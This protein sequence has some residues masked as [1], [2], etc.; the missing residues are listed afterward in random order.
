MMAAISKD[1]FDVDRLFTELKGI[2]W[3]VDRF[4][5]F[6]SNGPLPPATT[7][8]IQTLID[9]VVGKL[10]VMPDY[11]DV[12]LKMEVHFRLKNLLE[13]YRTLLES[14]NTFTT[15]V[16]PVTNFEVDPQ[17]VPSSSSPVEESS[18]TISLSMTSLSSSLTDSVT[19][20]SETLIEDERDLLCQ[21]LNTKAN[22]ELLME[23][24]PVSK[25]LLLDYFMK[26]CKKVGSIDKAENASFR[27]Q[28]DDIV[29]QLLTRYRQFC[30]SPSP[31]I[32]SGSS[33]SPTTMA[34]EEQLQQLDRSISFF[35][36]LNFSALALALCLKIEQL[37]STIRAIPRS[38]M[39]LLAEWETKLAHTWE[40]FWALYPEGL[41]RSESTNS[42]MNRTFINSKQGLRV[43]NTTFTT[44]KSSKGDNNSNRISNNFTDFYRQNQLDKDLREL[45][46]TVLGRIEAGE[47][48]DVIVDAI[49]RLVQLVEDFAPPENE[50]VDRVVGLIERCVNWVSLCF[51]LFHLSKSSFV[52]GKA[53]KQ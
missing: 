46:A 40:H 31:S 23:I 52:S 27:A 25:C 10:K 15:W 22:I 29:L 24:L 42:K 38:Q 14:T 11:L 17:N 6:T 34:I 5:V 43:L 1:Q 8:R 50:W 41:E 33:P 39:R 47:E 28:W 3:L 16:F 2:D 18:L 30:R 19:L 49:I 21:L 53:F 7:E 37:E 44:S 20:T 12:H 13:K 45:E 9:D 51:A 32:F 35:F 36:A 4:L 48:Q 26:L